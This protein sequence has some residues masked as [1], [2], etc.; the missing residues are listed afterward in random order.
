MTASDDDWRLRGQETYLAGRTLAWRSWTSPRPDWDHDHC[1]FCWDEISD[2]PVDEHV[3]YNSAWVT[4][5]DTYHWICPEC[6]EDFRQR[7]AW[8]VEPTQSDA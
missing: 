6:F 5:D 4:S 2:R 3:R 8:K 7:F 1:D